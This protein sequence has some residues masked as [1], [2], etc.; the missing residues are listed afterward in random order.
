MVKVAFKVGDT[1]NATSFKESE[2]LEIVPTANAGYE[3]DSVSYKLTSAEDDTYTTVTATE[4]KYT[5][6]GNAIAGDITVKVTFRAINYTITNNTVAEN[7]NSIAIKVGDVDATTATIGQT[8]TIVP[9]LAANYKVSTLEVKNGDAA[10]QVT[11]NTFVMPAANVTV[12]A[13]F[14]ISSCFGK[15]TFNI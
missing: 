4:G 2:T 9:T 12:T 15:S 5:V 14:C 10:V 6:A 8:V 3:L 1:E 13:T 11:N 7:G